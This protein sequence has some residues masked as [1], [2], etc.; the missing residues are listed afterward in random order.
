MAHDKQQ[1]HGFTLLKFVVKQAG[2]GGLSIADHFH[3]CLRE[4]YLLFGETR[5]ACLNICLS[6]RFPAKLRQFIATSH[7]LV[8]SWP[9]S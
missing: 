5:G 2:F 7:R 1:E 9:E 4:V 8:V 3:A 6:P